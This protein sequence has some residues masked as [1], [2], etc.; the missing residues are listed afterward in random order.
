MYRFGNGRTVS[1]RSLETVPR[2]ALNAPYP[3]LLLIGMYLPFLV[4]T[5]QQAYDVASKTSRDYELPG[6]LG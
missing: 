2:Y 6:C 1:V 3:S 5:M 4:T